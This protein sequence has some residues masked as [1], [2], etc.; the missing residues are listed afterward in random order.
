M[1]DAYARMSGT[2]GR[3]VTVHQ[4][5]GLTNAMT[6]ITEA[7]KSRTPLVV[8]AAEATRA[9]VE[10]PHRPGRPRRRRRRGPERVARRRDGRRR[11]RPR[12]TG[13]ARD[14]RR[15][16]VLN[17]PLDVQ[18]AQ[19]A[20]RRG[21]RGR[22]RCPTR[23]RRRRTSARLV[24]ALA[25]AQRPVFVAGRG[26]RRAGAASRWRA[27]PSGCG[28]LLATSAVA[29]G[30]FA[31]QPVVARTSP[32]GSPRR[33]RR[34]DRAAPTSIVG[35]GCALNMWTTRHGRADRPARDGRAGRPRRR[36]A[37]RAPADRP[38]RARRRRARPRDAAAAALG[39]MDGRLPDRRASR[40][41]RRAGPLARRADSTTRRR[42][43]ASIRGRS[44]IAL[45]DLLP[46]ERVVAIDSGNF[47][48]YPSMY[49]S[50]PDE[51]GFCF[52]QAFQSIGLG[53]ATAIGAALA[54]PDRFRSPRSATAA[55]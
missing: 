38:R 21:R 41:D 17:L 19:F 13:P 35:W 2:V 39:R 18:A 23:A 50:V 3:A 12:R 16:V 9:V 10:L 25:R 51:F 26:A 1:A 31:R 6:G 49:L 11:R 32:A 48:G 52:T 54:R 43:S 55:R 53:L 15:T 37:R 5:C 24:D 44:R 29:N 36:R 33:W 4:G 14:E 45:D 42:P 28:A 20:G 27:R 46:A 40:P 8:L 47:M 30:L 7:A 22:R 34:A